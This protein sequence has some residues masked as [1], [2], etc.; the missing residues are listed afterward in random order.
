MSSEASY[1]DTEAII[2]V[3]STTWG[4]EADYDENGELICVCCPKPKVESPSMNAIDYVP[5]EDNF[6]EPTLDERVWLYEEEREA[7]HCLYSKW[8]LEAMIELASYGLHT[9]EEGR[10]AFRKLPDYSIVTA[11]VN[12]LIARGFQGSGEPPRML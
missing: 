1:C 11:T 6:D 5:M 4:S 7:R 2:E 12:D 9:D 8:C 10:S 3:G